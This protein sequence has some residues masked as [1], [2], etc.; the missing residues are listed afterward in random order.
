MWLFCDWISVRVFIRKPL[1]VG[2]DRVL[3]LTPEGE[4]LWAKDL[5]A[6]VEADEG[7]GSASVAVKAVDWQAL[8]E[9]FV[10]LGAVSGQLA[11]KV[12]ERYGAWLDLNNL[13]GQLAVDISGNPTKWMNKG[14]NVWGSPSMVSVIGL[15]LVDVL[16][17]SGIDL[18]VN[19]LAQVVSLKGCFVTRFDLTTNLTFESQIAKRE[20]LLS[21]AGQAESKRGK[22]SVCDT[23]S[24]FGDAA[25]VQTKFYDKAGEVEYQGR[26]LRL[27]DKMTEA[28]KERVKALAER[29]AAAVLYSNTL[30]RFEVRIGRG[31]IK[32]KGLR[33]LADLLEHIEGEKGVEFMKTRLDTLN[34]GQMP[35]GERE[36]E[37]AQ[38][39]IERLAGGKAVS[40]GCV[41]MFRLWAKGDEVKTAYP[42]RTYYKW[43]KEILQAVG[44]DVGLVRLEEK[45][46]REQA[47]KVVPL[48]RVIE[49][50]TAAPSKEAMADFWPFRANA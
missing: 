28:E 19:E 45:E 42:R 3:R 16:R 37:Q 15:F 1:K 24:Y 33:R 41:G 11:E 21:M 38:A 34:L 14:L 43:R 31:Y 29:M 20:F 12:K 35:V 5:W 48:V 25:W 23:T 6:K 9:P 27:K 22:K 2:G 49:A 26:K 32:D 36:I 10:N 47:A 39:T 40:A 30:A 8:C 17:A 7:S 18:D 50:T 4:Q 44:V 13:E 46:R